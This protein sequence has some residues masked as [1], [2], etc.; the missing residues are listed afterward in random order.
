MGVLGA[1]KK[2]LEQIIRLSPHLFWLLRCGECF[3]KYGLNNITKASFSRCK[4]VLSGYIP[5][6]LY[7]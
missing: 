3:K 4:E 6:I 5:K 1:A 7:R 2:A